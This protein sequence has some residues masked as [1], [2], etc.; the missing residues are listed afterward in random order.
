M[1]TTLVSMM[2]ALGLALAGCGGGGSKEAT[3]GGQGQHSGEIVLAAGANT[4]VPGTLKTDGVVLQSASWN[5]QATS[6]GVSL[7]TLANS[8]CAIALKQDF[9]P[10]AGGGSSTWQCDLVVVAPQVDQDTVYTLTLTGID[11]RS[12][13]HSVSRSL[14]VTRSDALNPARFASAAGSNVS[15]GSGQPGTLRC[16]AE[17]ASWYQWSVIDAGGQSVSLSDSSGAEVHF[18]APV[19]GAATPLVFECRVAVQER[20]F[21]SRVTVTVQPASSPTLA[22]RGGITGSRFVIRNSTASYSAAASWVD[23]SG[24]GGSGAAPMY[25]WDFAGAVPP[26]VVLTGI[27]G[28]AAS[29][30]MTGTP[31]LPALLPLRVTATAGGQQS[32]ARMNVLLEPTTALTLPTITPAAQTV[33]PG[34]K[35]SI[36]A[37]GQATAQRFAWAALSGPPVVLAGANT[38]TVEFIAPAVS[39]PTDIVLRVAIGHHNF[40]A[41]GPLAAFLDTVVRVAP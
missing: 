12:Q 39:G 36:T 19:V 26:E 4:T 34:T 24:A 23:A 6:A 40:N 31:S 27:G 7:P 29:V 1:R 17:G 10:V 5:L 32:S 3:I 33:T 37:T 2:A 25:S 28:G 16:A 15:A 38:K 11:N 18:A 20:V 21:T 35:V 9:A 8:N 41:E 22:V 13:A 14:R 30:S